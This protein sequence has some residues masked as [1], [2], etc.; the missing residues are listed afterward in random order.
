MDILENLEET[1]K[2]SDVENDTLIKDQIIGNEEGFGLDLSRG[3]SVNSNTNTF[4]SPIIVSG[5]GE[6]SEYR[7]YMLDLKAISEP[8]LI[9]NNLSTWKRVGRGDKD[10]Q[11]QLNL[12]V[13]LGKWESIIS[14]EERKSEMKRYKKS[15]P[16]VE[17]S[18][19]QQKNGDDQKLGVLE[20]G[21]IVK[22]ELEAKTISNIDGSTMESKAQ[23][24]VGRGSQLSPPRWSPLNPNKF[25]LNSD[26]VVDGSR[27][28]VGVGPVI[29]NSKGC[30]MATSSQQIF[31]SYSLMV[32]EVVAILKGLQF[33]FDISLEPL[34]LASDAAKVVRM[35]N[36]TKDH[37]SEIGL[38]IIAIRR[39]MLALPNCV[40]RF[41]P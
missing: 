11:N 28:I 39:L 16:V 25:L 10:E 13:K 36:D 41:T 38:V 26:V 27:R 22:V 24:S 9:P 21:N 37:T 29:R 31:A 18:P 23:I 20:R 33:A 34:D 8:N 2:L 40:I 17:K 4:C 6:C 35:V 1:R 12:G 7:P 30:V 3:P 5:V 32:A 14:G 15:I 19:S